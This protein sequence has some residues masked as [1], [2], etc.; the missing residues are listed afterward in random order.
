MLVIASRL[1]LRFGLPTDAEIRLQILDRVLMHFGD[2]GAL[3][4]IEVFLRLLRSGKN[5]FILQ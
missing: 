5:S 3:R 1:F 4:L 2:E